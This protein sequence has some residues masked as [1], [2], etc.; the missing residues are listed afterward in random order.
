MEQTLYFKNGVLYKIDPD[1]DR[2]YYSARYYVSDGMAFDLENASDLANIPIPRYEK[3]H[4]MPNISHSIDYVLRRKA[5]D[6]KNKGKFDLSIKCLR[7]AN[8]LMSKSP[9]H[10]SKSDYFYIVE[11]LSLVNRF[12]EAKEEKE[13]I[14]N[15]YFSNYDF[16]TMHRTVLQKALVL[17]QELNTDLVEADESPNCNELCAKYRKRIYSISGRDKRFPALTNEIYYSGLIFY[18]FIEG[19][20]KPRYCSLIDIVEYNNRP[21]IDDRTDEEKRNY[22]CFFKQRILKDRKAADLLEY[23][24][25]CAYI[26]LLEPM[27]FKAYQDIK[28]ANTKDFQ[29]LMQV[30]EEAGIDIELYQ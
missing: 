25:I 30:A 13:F 8:Q 10:W 3:L 5:G 17:A 6:L 28:Y 22:E 23:C 12:Y 21:F 16:D 1:D 26:P 27:N 14:E 2:N 24:Q 7:K 4:G 19:I 20:N 29:E 15:N 11:E 9:I 18:P